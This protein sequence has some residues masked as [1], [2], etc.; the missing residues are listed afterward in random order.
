MRFAIIFIIVSLLELGVLSAETGEPRYYDL[1]DPHVR[2]R[3]DIV[4][5][6]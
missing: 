4:L 6:P 2:L 5:E 1:V 3:H